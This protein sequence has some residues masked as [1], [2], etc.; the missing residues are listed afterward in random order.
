V[1]VLVTGAAGFIGSHVV[2]HLLARGEEVVGLDSYDEFYARAIKDA[3]LAR[4]RD[5]GR[6][7]LIEGDIRDRDKVESL[8]DGIEAIV[9]LAA[10]AGV[11]PSIQDPFTYA[12]VNVLG[13]QVILD[14]VRRRG[15][16]SFVFGS[17]S[18]VYGNNEKVPFSEE[19]R[20]DAPI[21]PYAATKRSGELL[22]H[23]QTHLFGT[24][25][26]CLRF[27][28]VYGPRQRPDLAIRKFSKKVLL[29]EPLPRFGDGRTARDYTYVN[30]IVAGVDAAVGFVANNPGRFEI[31]NLGEAATV[32]LAEMIEV[33]GEVFDREPHVTELP[34]EPGDVERTCAD[35]TK[36]GALLGYRPT[37]AFRAGMER[38]AAW[39]LSE[40]ARQ[41][42][43][44]PA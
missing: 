39:Y 35:V 38:F 11:R 18:S 37:T 14:L 26:V 13:T 43:V 40:G 29:G 19:D 5:H 44:A 25:C 34:V 24:A 15:I 6:F 31:V 23:A 9:H 12:D 3:N 27:F 28:T 8:P 20:V 17:S 41:D 42:G 36:A 10:R 30:D 16:P 32:T 2:D 33:V 21:S 4:A 22:C 7:R 1:A